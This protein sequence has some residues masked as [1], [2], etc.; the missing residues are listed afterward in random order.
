MKKQFKALVPR[1]IS[2]ALIFCFAFPS[3]AY[4]MGTMEAEQSSEITMLDSGNADP[5]S[6]IET[7][8]EEQTSKEQLPDEEPTAENLPADNKVED[9][10]AGED[11][12]NSES[13]EEETSNETSTNETSL[14]EIP[15]ELKTEET[16]EVEVKDI[17]EKFTE[18]EQVYLKEE[19]EEAQEILNA[20]AD[21]TPVNSG[22]VNA[23]I[24]Y[25][26]DSSTKT[27]TFTGKGAMP[28]ITLQNYLQNP[29]AL[30]GYAASIMHQYNINIVFEEG[31]TSIGAMNFIMVDSI[32][33]IKMPSTMTSIGN[34]A[35]IGTDFNNDITIPKSINKIGIAAFAADFNGKKVSFEE[36]TK[37][38]TIPSKCFMVASIGEIDIPD[39]VTTISNFAF[40]VGF[41]KHSS[42]TLIIPKKVKS[43]GKYAFYDYDKCKSIEF[44]GN[45]P[46][47]GA[48]SFA[49]MD[50]IAYYPADNKTYTV[51]KRKSATNQFGSVTWQAKGEIADALTGTCGENVTWTYDDTTKKLTISGTGAMSDYSPSNK[52]PWYTYDIGSV[53]IGSGITSIGAYAFTNLAIS[54]SFTM[55]NTV[56]AIGDGAFK[57]VVIAY[58]ADSIVTN[59]VNYKSIGKSAFENAQLVCATKINEFNLSNATVIGKKAFYKGRITDSSSQLKGKLT[60][61]KDLKKIESYSFAN[62]KFIEGDLTIP[63]GIEYIEPYAFYDTDSYDG[64]IIISDTVK[65]IS[66]YAFYDNKAN[67]YVIGNGVKNI[68]KS[69]F[70]LYFKDVKNVKNIS[71]GTGV[72]YIGSR[73][74]RVGP[75]A[76]INIYGPRM[77]V[78]VDAF[79]GG[80]LV[81]YSEDDSWDD[82][83]RDNAHWLHFLSIDF[84]TKLVNVTLDYT[85]QATDN[86]PAIDK[87][88]TV[89]YRK[90]R[91][92]TLPENISVDNESYSLKGWVKNRNTVATQSKMKFTE[93]TTLYAVYKND[94]GTYFSGDVTSRVAAEMGYE[95]AEDIPKGIWAYLSD[96]TF[97]YTGRP[98]ELGSYDIDV[99]EN[100][101]CLK[102]GTDYTLKFSNNIK[103]G[104][105]TCKII[106][107]GGYS[108]TKIINYTITPRKLNVND[109]RIHYNKKDAASIELSKNGKVQKPAI[110][111]YDSDNEKYLKANV[112]YTVDY[113]GTNKKNTE[114]Y[115]P[116]AFK[117]TGKYKIIVTGKGG[118][119]GTLKCNVVIT[120]KIPMTKCKVANMPTFADI[121]ADYGSSYSNAMLTVEYKGRALIEDVDYTVSSER[122]M[123]KGYLYYTFEAKNESN[124]FGEL[125]TKIRI[126]GKSISGVYAVLSPNSNY[127]GVGLP[128][129]SDIEVYASKAAALKRD[130][131]KLLSEYNDYRISSINKNAN[132]IGITLIAYG[133]RYGYTGKKNLTV[134]TGEKYTNINSCKIKQIPYYKIGSTITPFYGFEVTK[135]KKVL[136]GTEIASKM[137]TNVD[138]FYG[139]SS[140]DSLGNKT[141]KFHGNGEYFG[142]KELSIE[143]NVVD[144]SKARIVKSESEI[145]NEEGVVIIDN[146]SDTVYS[147]STTNNGPNYTIRFY[148]KNYETGKIEYEILK[149]N[150]D[151][152]ITYSGNNK[153]GKATA[154]INGKRGFKGKKAVKYNVVPA[155]ASKV[156]SYKTGV[157]RKNGKWSF[158][159]SFVVK[160]NSGTYLQPGRDYTFEKVAYI[161]SKYTRAVTKNDEILSGNVLYVK[162]KLKGNYTGDIRLYLYLDDNTLEGAKVT[163]KP[164]T[165]SKKS[166]SGYIKPKMEDITVTKKINGEI[167]V[168]PQEYYYIYGCK[169]NNKAGTATIT[170]IGE[171]G[172][173]WCGR[174]T[175]KYKINAQKAD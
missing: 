20:V 169:N 125:T 89:Q 131:S 175:G 76:K 22:K 75:A 99:Y 53:E 161:D 137:D 31:I 9:N 67:A 78:E 140:Y 93:D 117:D 109:Y 26:Y 148:Y 50:V 37:I 24:S 100:D 33:S 113:V 153:V 94:T 160:H 96:D 142:T 21:I 61:S 74:F 1:M 48:N 82:I 95:T 12:S 116:S 121:N 112:D 145:S 105:A 167:V 123:E 157:Y 15:E 174:I 77:E 23:N 108:G 156:I 19:L 55:P 14:E 138:Y 13:S 28:N 32:N 171:N 168:I 87:V 134:N 97:K 122:D 29:N 172:K 124:Y 3:N 60:L 38:T 54:E 4:A 51:A 36:G 110:K 6:L 143:P 150:T 68:E 154:T 47:I 86:H 136:K 62:V 114:T 41:D 66:E 147:P 2:L 152:T 30:P 130:Y 104:T 164:Q 163:V 149:K 111:V 135:G 73:A 162:G 42:D 56:T 126:K 103:P 129:P 166:A 58:K 11:I 16:D 69:A 119:S 80:G 52:A 128:D 127:N 106:F 170:L 83:S 5:E 92:I 115:N 7:E 44:K 79:T 120:D 49:G 39:S 84:K 40:Y 155:P 151:Y 88:E 158:P 107:K 70:E 45:M 46:S 98:I 17:S 43:I 141:V 133:G 146:V 71:L 10:P 72:E 25:S 81:I 57:D 65:E 91:N 27:I 59:M 173:G 64:S 34:C 159:K 139:F 8:T 85:S 18:E 144:I 118:Y 132:G 101:V 90:N 35:F 63:E 102:K 165:Y